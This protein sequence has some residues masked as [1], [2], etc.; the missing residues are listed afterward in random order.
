VAVVVASRSRKP[1]GRG[2]AEPR[3]GKAAPVT[4]AGYAEAQLT[5]FIAKFDAADQKLIRA[6]RKVMRR[7][8]PSAHEL[9]YDNY[10]FF[11]IGY[12][13]TE[14]PS[15]A[16]LSIAAG[17]SGVSLCFLHGAKL[18]DPKKVLLGSGKQTR[19]IR[20]PSVGVLARP[21]V[22]ALLAAAVARS[23]RSFAASGRGKLIIRSV[24][25]KQ[26]PRRH[27]RA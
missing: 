13:P 7:R 9:V 24:S 27:T 3:S 21:E 11:V 22:D 23:R 12:S 15:D 5:E 16:I 4:R 18:P 26:R 19:F 25:A 20:L 17:S 10:N 14:R 1:R 2:A 8:F 6:V